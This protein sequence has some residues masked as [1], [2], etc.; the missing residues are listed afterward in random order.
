VTTKGNRMKIRAFFFLILFTQIVSGNAP[1]TWVKTDWDHNV[2]NTAISASYLSSFEKELI[3]EINKVR[4]NPTKY[5][6]EYIAPLKSNAQLKEFNFNGYIKD[7]YMFYKPEKPIPGIDA[8]KLSS[9]LIHNR[10]NFR[11]YPSRNFTF[12]MEARNRLFF[13]QLIREFPQYEEYIDN[14]R[15]VVDLSGTIISGNE[16]FL[17]SMIDRA[18]IEY[19]KG[20]WQ[21]RGGRQRINWGLNLVWNPNDI[22]NTFSYFDFDYEERPGTDAVKIQYYTG[23]TSSAE[24]V[25]KIGNNANETAVAGMYRFSKFSYDFQ[26]LGGWVG[27]DLVLGT[28]W[29]GD[30]EGGGFRG[31]ASWFIPRNDKV[32]SKE[33]LVASISGDYTFKNSLYLHG[34]VL[35][36]THGTTGKAG[37]R[38]FFEHDISVKNLSMGRWNLFSQISYPFTPLFS[39]NISGI[40]NPCDGSFFLGPTLTYSLGN[41]LELMATGQ[42]FFGETVTEYGE[43]GKALFGRLKWSF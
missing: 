23:F 20:N 32:Y 15:G 19:I 27:K 22:F 21:I 6:K 2:L 41:N 11:W 33:A 8:D 14:D 18:W 26:F 13:G 31:E 5:S 30:I 35:Y 38:Q 40:M 25:Y 16:W 17:H 9:N 28:G 1:E 10:L 12:A 24:L 36:N 39:G 34:S 37:G 43:L 29:T 3:L 7:L 4:S 42:L